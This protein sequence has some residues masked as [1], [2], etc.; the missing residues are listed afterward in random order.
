MP[1][2]N[3]QEV[4]ATGF[5]LMGF[6]WRDDP[7]PNEQAFEALRA[8]LK[9]GMNF[10]NG[11]EFYG[12]PECNSMTLLEAYFA[13]YPEDADKVVLSIKGAVNLDNRAPDGSPEGVRRSIDTVLKQ[14]KGRKKLD[15]F[16]CARRDPKVPMEATFRTMQEYIDKGLLGGISLSEVAASTIHE[17][18]KHAKIVAVEVELSIFSPEVL[19]N[20]VAAACAQY[21]IPLIAYSP[22]GRGML[23]G[24]M[25]SQADIPPFLQRFPRFYPENFAH[26]LELV[27]KVKALAEKRGCTPAQLAISWTRCLSRRPGMPT[28]IPIPGT[29]RSER[30][31]ENAVEVDLTD[32]EM[33]EID[34]ILAKFEVKGERYG[35][36][37]PVNT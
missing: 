1:Q 17:A 22:V 26:N 27:N 9:K 24:K 25:Q 11:G 18:V 12:T 36:G 29:T 5:G 13:K 15:I 7:I 32:A 20:G 35:A 6:T 33:N 14:L 28:I 16:E 19:T 3:G 2:I 34:E 21:N 8:A 30:V 37:F 31:E 4:G 10:W 23:A